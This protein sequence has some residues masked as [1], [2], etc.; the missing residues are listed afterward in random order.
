MQI[1]LH[2]QTT[3]PLGQ[4][5]PGPHSQQGSFLPGPLQPQD[6]Y[7]F[8]QLPVGAPHC[9]LSPP[10]LLTPLS[11]N[12]PCKSLLRNIWDEVFPQGP[13]RMQL[14]NCNTSWI[15]MEQTLV[16]HNSVLT[17]SPSLPPLLSL[18]IIQKNLEKVVIWNPLVKPKPYPF[19]CNQR[20]AV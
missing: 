10:P 19:R 20:R 17:L 9:P 18:A 12:S 1:S 16:S 8:T 13:W 14:D 3:S 7:G 5:L 4:P 6:G 2:L 15:N 11:A